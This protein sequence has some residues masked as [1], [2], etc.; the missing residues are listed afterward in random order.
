L[1][2]EKLVSKIV[3]RKF[4][5]Q[6][7]KILNLNN[8]DWESMTLESKDRKSKP[9]ATRSE[10]KFSIRAALA[11]LGI[12]FLELLLPVIL[13]GAAVWF[14]FVYAYLWQYDRT[15]MLVLFGV[16]V[17][18]IALPL[19]I[20]IDRLLEGIRSGYYPRG[21]KIGKGANARMLKMAM[22]GM[23]I[24]ISLLIAASLVALPANILPQP[25]TAMQYL[26]TTAERPVVTAPPEEIGRLAIQSR[27]PS[28]K[29]L[30]IQV[31]EGFRSEE[32]LEQ[33]MRIAMEDP[34]ALQDG[35]IR[36][37]LQ[38]AIASY[39][40]T[41]KEPLLTLFRS[42]PPGET[43]SSGFPDDLYDRY[44]SQSFAGVAQEIID[45]TP[46]EA[47]RQNTLS[48]LEA[49]Q[50]QLEQALST[51]EGNQLTSGDQRLD[52]VLQTL[53][54][55]D[56]QQDN[57]LLVFAKSTADD[58]RY[59]PLVR[60]NALLLIAKFGDQ[61]EFENL[62]SYLASEERFIQTRALQAILIL[63]NQPG[64]TISPNQ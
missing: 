58:T 22:G 30:S 32:A 51:L 37:A 62:F 18:I 43:Q 25:M 28:T 41:A 29:I 24:P 57:D 63:Q 45:A 52:F 48:Q 5:V 2:K 31:L 12:M 11:L 33:L 16:L 36:T 6:L 20:M 4:A 50:S 34:L 19:S 3:K 35:S 44:F 26:I 14:L 61:S 39:G 7:R 38:K 1:R 42:I 17:T 9:E 64:S 40:V 46:D 55:F 27:N 59:S 8:N 23:L 53:M 60:G 54:L 56:V 49:A 13:A 10:S 15:L 21:A 47:E